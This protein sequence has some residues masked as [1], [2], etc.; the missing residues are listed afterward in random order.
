MSS[1]LTIR[2]EIEKKAYAESP[3][4]KL[5]R[6][7]TKIYDG[8]KLQNKAFP[9]DVAKEIYDIRDKHEKDQMAYI[10]MTLKRDKEATDK[11]LFDA[12]TQEL[13]VINKYQKIND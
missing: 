11:M 9:E 3:Q 5:E 2:K 7:L 13:E 6:Q 12:M 1:A 10:E 8:M 4:G